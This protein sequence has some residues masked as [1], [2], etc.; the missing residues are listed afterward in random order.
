MNLPELRWVS[1]KNDDPSLPVPGGLSELIEQLESQKI[2]FPQ[3]SAPRFLDQLRDCVKRMPD[4]LICSLLDGDPDLPLEAVLGY[5]QPQRI[6]DALLMLRKVTGINRVWLIHDTA[7]PAEWTR[8]LG[9]L[10]SEARIRRIFIRNDYPQSDPTL[11]L[12]TLLGR[13]LRPGDLATRHGVLLLDAVTAW[14][15]SDPA[16]AENTPLAVRDLV[17]NS[18]EFVISPIGWS[19]SELLSKLQITFVDRLIRASDPLRDV[20]TDSQMQID[21]AEIALHLM[22]PERPVN[23]DPC[24]RCGWCVEGC[25]VRIQ[26]AGLLEAAQRGDREM[27]ERYGLHACIECGICSYVCPSR[28]PLLAGIRTL[29]S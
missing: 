22:R 23:P 13:R 25:P 9:R 4:R 29:R 3:R 26:P 19:L 12:Y 24:V 1:P 11:L 14:R 6:V 7:L 10:A 21:G 27:A 15:L 20:R 18:S 5:R 16:G 8:E 17:G 2:S 28:L